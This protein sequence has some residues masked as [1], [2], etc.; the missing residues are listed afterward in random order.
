MNKKIILASASPRRKELLSVITEDFLVLPSDAE[1]IIPGDISADETAEYLAKIKAQAVAADHPQD[2]VIG[3]DTCVV[4]GNEILGKPVDF[5]DAKRMLNL[6]SGK[7]HK[8]ITGC[9]IIND[10]KTISFSSQ[11][12]VEFYPL[13]ETQIE[14]YINSL[15]PYDKAGSYA[16]QGKASLFV[17]GIKG[18]Y[19][20]VVGLPVAELNLK[21]KEM[22][23]KFKIKKT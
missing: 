12:E 14:E 5:N 4:V 18:D 15:E 22:D 7:T 17:K 11:T 19:F 20:N 23:I 13:S 16:I 21:L 3:A 2:V 1:E 8:V 6:L 9:A 10:G